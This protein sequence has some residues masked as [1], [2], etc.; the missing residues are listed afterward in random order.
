MCY[1]PIHIKKWLSCH[2]DY[3][4]FKFIKMNL[5]ELMVN[6]L[7]D[8]SFLNPVCAFVKNNR[9]FVWV[10]TK[11]GWFFL[12]SASNRVNSFRHTLITSTNYLSTVG[13]ERD[14]LDISPTK[15]LCF[16]REHVWVQPR[17]LSQ[18]SQ[19]S[20]RDCVF[21]P[22][23]LVHA[24]RRTDLSGLAPLWQLGY[25]LTKMHTQRQT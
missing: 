18:L 22:G 23:T 24:D 8:V 4:T 10:I 21:L 15:L 14:H 6:K 11:K 1:I 7:F 9:R 5:L 17:V 19:C 25:L 20:W 13:R 2:I 16:R 12:S 3:L